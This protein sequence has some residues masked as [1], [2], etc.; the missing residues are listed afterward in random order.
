MCLPSGLFFPRLFKT[1]INVELLRF[2]H[3]ES[4]F[5][6]QKRMKLKEQERCFYA[7]R[8]NRLR[9]IFSFLDVLELLQPFSFDA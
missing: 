8:L 2:F 1:F 6:S 9:D 7:I 5:L 4:S 3:A